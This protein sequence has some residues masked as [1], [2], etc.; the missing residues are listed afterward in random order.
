M[1]GIGDIAVTVVV[2]I[3]VVGIG[4]AVIDN[5]IAVIVDPI[6]NFVCIGTNVR[7]SIIAI[8]AI[9]DIPFTALTIC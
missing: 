2:A 1:N 6:T 4:D 8:V 9:K 5:A 3:G 7:I